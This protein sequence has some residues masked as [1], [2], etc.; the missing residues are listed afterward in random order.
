MS[1]YLY[2]LLVAENN[3]LAKVPHKYS[4][5]IHKELWQEKRVIKVKLKVVGVCLFSELKGWPLL[6]LQHHMKKVTLLLGGGDE[7][8]F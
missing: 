7:M 5:Y 2:W 4:L 8:E 3:L 1:L 6:L